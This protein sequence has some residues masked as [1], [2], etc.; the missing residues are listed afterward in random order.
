MRSA[1]FSVQLVVD[2]DKRNGF[3][4]PMVTAHMPPGPPRLL[5]R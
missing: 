3:P 1:C 4:S 2:R 5:F